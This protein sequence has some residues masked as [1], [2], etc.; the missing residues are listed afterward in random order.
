[1]TRMTD[2][3]PNTYDVEGSRAKSLLLK[4]DPIIID[5][6]VEM[7]EATDAEPDKP[8]PHRNTLILFA[9][10]GYRDRGGAIDCSKH[11]GAPIDAIKALIKDW[12]AKPS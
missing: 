6:A 4:D 8:L 1:M 2:K 3:K 10:L 9:S 5:M 7:M 12:K 11:I